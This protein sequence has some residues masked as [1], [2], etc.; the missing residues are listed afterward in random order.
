MLS[1]YSS[2]VQSTLGPS[3]YFR[4]HKKEPEYLDHSLFLPF[5]NNEKDHPKAKINR[6]R[7][8]SLNYLTMV[9]F[10]KDPIIYPV[11]SSWFGQTDKA[12]KVVPMEETT[13]FKENLFGLKTLA[14]EKRIEKKEIDGVHL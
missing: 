10:L 5:L 6:K 7:F 4:D 8:E 9:K 12:G 14:E 13:I 2:V 3:N 11:E 1:P